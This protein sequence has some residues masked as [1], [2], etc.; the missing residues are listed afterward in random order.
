MRYNTKTKDTCCS[1]SSFS[2]VNKNST[3]VKHSQYNCNQANESS[4]ALKSA[5]KVVDEKDSKQ[6]II[7]SVL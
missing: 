1:F 2:K 6:L 5:K 7:L 4:G 3:N